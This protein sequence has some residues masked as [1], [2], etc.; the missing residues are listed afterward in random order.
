MGKT[1]INK[2][3]SISVFSNK[4]MSILN[5]TFAPIKTGQKNNK[6]KQKRQKNI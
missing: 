5:T 6:L 4:K 3:N 2:N 1:K